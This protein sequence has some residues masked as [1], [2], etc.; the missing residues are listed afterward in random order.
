[1]RQ[2]PQFFLRSISFS[3]VCTTKAIS[4][5]DWGARLCAIWKSGSLK[6][7]LAQDFN[8]L[9][10]E[11]FEKNHDLSVND[12]SVTAYQWGAM[13]VA[14]KM[15]Q[16]AKVAH[17]IPRNMDEFGILTDLGSTDG[18]GAERLVSSGLLSSL[19]DPTV[20]KYL[21]SDLAIE[22]LQAMQEK[23]GA[24]LQAERKETLK[25][26]SKDLQDLGMPPADYLAKRNR[27][28]L[29]DAGALVNTLS[30]KSAEAGFVVPA[31]FAADTLESAVRNHIRNTASAKLGYIGM[32]T[33]LRDCLRLVGDAIM[34]L[35][36][37]DVWNTSPHTDALPIVDTGLGSPREAEL[38][39]LLESSF[40]RDV[41]IHRGGTLMG[42]KGFGK[43]QLVLNVAL[44]KQL[45]GWAL[46]EGFAGY[47]THIGMLCTSPAGGTRDA[48]HKAPPTAFLAAGLRKQGLLQDQSVP[49]WAIPGEGAFLARDARDWL[50]QQNIDCTI[51]IDETQQMYPR[52][53]SGDQKQDPLSFTPQQRLFWDIV[54][55]IIETPGFPMLLLTGTAS[56]LG[57]AVYERP[58]TTWMLEVQRSKFP[59][60]WLENRYTDI[61]MLMMLLRQPGLKAMVSSYP[62]WVPSFATSDAEPS[63]ASVAAKVGVVHPEDVV[64]ALALELS[65]VPEDVAATSTAW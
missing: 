62:D 24:A 37:T 45:I 2:G 25:Q 44:C 40:A 12:V 15:Y 31:F 35:D 57:E 30:R 42:F 41:G 17:E 49:D 59:R 16:K 26:E 5:G 65:K 9:V 14:H 56:H 33:A 48:L 10:R 32:A 36:A 29:P 11:E 53:L 21:R 7:F 1:M 28:V 8:A 47:R 58:D 63:L 54:D 51:V 52:R 27:V 39:R 60:R 6:L 38:Q 19:K 55:D 13:V 22:D 4:N 23:V 18:S 43:T 34:Y 61:E 3:A 46:P 64:L 20:S 50:I